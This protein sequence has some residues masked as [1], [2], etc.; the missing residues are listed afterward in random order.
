[1][2]TCI[3]CRLGVYSLYNKWVGNIPILAGPIC[4]YNLFATILGCIVV[5]QRRKISISFLKDLSC[6]DKLRPVVVINGWTH[7]LEYRVCVVPSPRIQPWNYKCTLNWTHVCTQISLIHWHYSMPFHLLHIRTLTLPVIWSH[8]DCKS[9]ERCLTS[10]V[11][12]S[13]FC[14]FKAIRKGG[15]LS[16]LFSFKFEAIIFVVDG[17]TLFIYDFGWLEKLNILTFWRLCVSNTAKWK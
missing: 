7:A 4:T 9:C 10:F 14:S 17:W 8:G 3:S 1:M 13:I 12:E 11:R 16:L 15:V 2:L 5:Y 6:N